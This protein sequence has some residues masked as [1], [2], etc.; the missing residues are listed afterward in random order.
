MT[1][2]EDFLNYCSEDN[3]KLKDDVE[4]WLADF[5]DLANRRI[6]LGSDEER[7]IKDNLSNKE[8]RR[9][10]GMT[11]D[12]FKENFKRKGRSQNA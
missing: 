7:W 1:I 9:I 8:Q 10:F 4:I 2:F 3:K 12:I 6:P 11:A 5:F